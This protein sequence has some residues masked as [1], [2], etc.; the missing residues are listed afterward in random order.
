MN[1]LL[2]IV[3]AALVLSGC[4]TT[5]TATQTTEETPAAQETA[6]ATSGQL[7][8]VTTDVDTESF[9]DIT[10]LA[11]GG[12]PALALLPLFE[13]G[14]S[15][16]IVDGPDN[17]QAEFTGPSNYDIVI[18]PTNLGVK[19]A[20]M[21]KTEYRLLD[22]VTWGNLYL[23]GTNQDQLSDTSI[24]VAAFG[25]E[26]VT[27]LVYKH[28][29]ENLLG[30]TTWYPSV[31]EAQAALL[32]GEVDVA[33]I[34]EPAAT[35]TIAKAKENGKEFTIIANLQDDWGDGGYPQAGLFVKAS[36]Y[37]ENKDAIDALETYIREYVDE[38]NVDAAPVV[39]AIDAVGAENL[40]VP[41][42]T[43]VSKTWNRL[44]LNVVRASDVQESLEKFLSIFGVEG[45]EKA[46]LE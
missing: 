22:V 2:K 25:E 38:A 32:S 6:Q 26:A 34:A 46:I 18:A 7:P 27:G 45:I 1:K 21:D 3:L 41:N 44:N 39:E 14:N 20:T 5:S 15:I 42:A 33:M 28:N 4:A 9:K 19:L 43:I 30:I 35:A 8:D 10:I 23:V 11:P 16:D 12:A 13:N 31:S 17:L 24:K 29:Y 40:S 37:E 36:T